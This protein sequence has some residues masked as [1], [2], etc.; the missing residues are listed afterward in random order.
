MTRDVRT[1]RYPNV[2]S[3]AILTILVLDTLLLNTEDGKEQENENGK[4]VFSKL[5]KHHSGKGLTKNSGRESDR[6]MG[7][8]L[9]LLVRS[10][11]GDAGD[12]K[13]TTL[14]DTLINRRQGDLREHN[15][16]EQRIDK[17]SE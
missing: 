1:K 11:V 10:R 9:P 13:E 5:S 16:V 7:S 3:M 15:F 6:F 12:G 4:C 17:A 2:S 14:T 8:Q